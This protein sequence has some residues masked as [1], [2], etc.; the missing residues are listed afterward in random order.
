MAI[1][2]SDDATGTFADNWVDESVGEFQPAYYAAGVCYIWCGTTSGNTKGSNI[3]NVAT[4]DIGGVCY[5]KF[6]L[7][8]Y[9]NQTWNTDNFTTSEHFFSII[10]SSPTFATAAGAYHKPEQGVGADSRIDIHFRTNISGKVTI[11]DRLNGSETTLLNEDFTYTATHNVIIKI[12]FEAEWIELYIDG[13]LIGS[14]QNLTSG[15]LADIGAQFKTNIHYHNYANY[16]LRYDDFEYEQ[17]DVEFQ[18]SIAPASSTSSVRL[19][20]G[21]IDDGIT[22]E[23]GMQDEISGAGGTTFVDLADQAGMDDTVDGWSEHERDLTDGAGLNDFISG[24]IQTEHD[25]TDQAGIDDSIDCLNWSEFLRDNQD[26]YII[27]YF[28]VLT[29][30]N[31]DTT[32]IEIPIKQF[33]ARKRDGEATYLSVSIP[34]FDHA[35]AIADRSNGQVIIQ[36]AYF[37]GA[38]EELREE[39][40]RVDLENIRTDEG[41]VNRA[42]TLSGHLTETFGGQEATLENPIYKYESEGIRRF[43]FAVPDPWINP[44][45]TAKIGGD[46]FRVGYITY[47]I[48]ERYRQMEITEAS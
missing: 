23:A 30:E 26:Q 45:D 43:R 14:R 20:G 5:F 40:L 8:E 27:K 38:V 29:G 46:E 39:I 33:Q 36:M 31:D 48:S 42:I 19:K 37:V 28:C 13:N 25:L 24:G 18:A 15:V 4:F 47:I 10:P 35:Q 1:I 17:I 41:P 12:H 44:G 32:D 9:L 3:Y 21:F 7:K 2:F 22:D 11:K 16:A 34:S 6:T